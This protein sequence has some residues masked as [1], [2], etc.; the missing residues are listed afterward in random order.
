MLTGQQPANTITADSSR[1]PGL[2]Y[3]GLLNVGFNPANNA[4]VQSFAT[5]TAGTGT[6]LTSSGRGS[7]VEIDNM[8][9]SM[10]NNYRISPTVIYVNAQEQR[11]ITNK[12]LT[13]ASGPLLH[14]NVQADGDNSRPYGVSRLGRRAL[15]LQ[16]VQRRRRLRYSRQG[17]SRI[18][19]R[20]R[21]SPTANACR[22][23][24]NRTR[25]PMSRK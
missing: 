6:F 13:N 8:L 18:C 9:V 24:I 12:C 4:Y 11:N 23:G 25:F 15:V 22:S 14:Y 3:D 10:W 2:A 17:S 5:G 1:N 7:V 21:S 16:S 20:A 19:R